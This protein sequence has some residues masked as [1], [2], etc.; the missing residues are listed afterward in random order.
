MVAGGG[1]VAGEEQGGLDE[2]LKALAWSKE[3]KS[4]LP[5]VGSRGGFW[6]WGKVVA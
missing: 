1:G 2:L 4:G 3:V 6:W 5:T